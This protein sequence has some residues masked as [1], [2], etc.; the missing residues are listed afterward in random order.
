M[1][2][3]YHISSTPVADVL[4]PKDYCEAVNEWGD[5]EFRHGG[6]A[7]S[8]VPESCF[9]NSIEGAILGKCSN[10]CDSKMFVYSCEEEPDVDLRDATAMDFGL[11][12]EVRYRRPVK[13]KKQCDFDLPYILRHKVESCSDENY[14]NEACGHIAKIKIRRWLKENT[15]CY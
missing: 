3:Y 6:F 5:L 4:E 14:F 12:K 2:K 1:S 7:E 9:A 15:D 13:V 10:G 11:I 8:D